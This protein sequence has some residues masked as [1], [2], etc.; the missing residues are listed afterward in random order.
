MLPRPIF[1]LLS[2]I[3]LFTSLVQ[4]QELKVQPTPFTVYLDFK[5]LFS[6]GA[7]L[8]SFPIWLESVNT[9]SQKN[10]EGMIVKTG[11]RLRFR[12]MAGLNDELML[13]V[14]F[15]DQKDTS[16]VVSAWNEIGRRALE[17]RALGLGIGLP[18]SETVT[19]PMTDV[20]YV[21]IEV[22]GDGSNVRGAFLSS[23]KKIETRTTL[24]F[25]PPTELTDPFQATAPAPARESDA[26]LFGRVKATLD[27]AIIKLSPRDGTSS[28]LELNSPHSRC[29]RSSRLKSSMP[30]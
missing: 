18:T 27:D 29:W 20:D 24:D 25:D 30:T 26:Y 15:D 22:P 7:P 19:I 2:A 8:P 23:V 9:E 17:P 3:F 6:P 13:R 16:P 10:G 5:A 14:F 11:F 21:E 28:T 1:H 12:K 4:A